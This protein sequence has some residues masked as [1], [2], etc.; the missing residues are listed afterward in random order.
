MRIGEWILLRLSR[1][2]GSHEYAGATLNYTVDNAL[3]FP[4]KTIPDLLERIKDK[5]I[6]DYGCGPGY[7]AVAMARLGAKSVVGVDINQAWLER[8]R[9]LAAENQCDD[10]A[11][12][13]EAGR[14]LEDSSN[15]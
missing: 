15:R 5:V 7:Q 2:P 4:K 9:A 13:S 14:F 11:S 8:A 1:K 3:D 10:R 12:F 6:L